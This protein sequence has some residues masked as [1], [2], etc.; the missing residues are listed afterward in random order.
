[1]ALSALSLIYGL[2]Y[3]QLFLGTLA[4]SG[5]MATLL[6]ILLLTGYGIGLYGVCVWIWGKKK[7]HIPGEVL[8][9][10]D[11]VR[12]LWRGSFRLFWNRSAMPLR[13]SWKASATSWAFWP[14]SLCCLA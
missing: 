13:R 11:S 1:M 8:A 7:A 9:G 4:L 10:P 5:M 6:R 3:T 2:A 12:F 14:S